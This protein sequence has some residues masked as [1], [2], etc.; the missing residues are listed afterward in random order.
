MHA[1]LTNEF[2]LGEQNA[3][4]Y[5]GDPAGTQWVV[6]KIRNTMYRPGPS[7]LD[8]NDDLGANSATFIWDMLGMYPENPGSG[9]LVFSSPGFPHEVI[10]L[11]SGKQITITSPGASPS[12]FYVK[13]LSINGAPDSK[14][15]VPFSRLAKG[16]M[17][18]WSLGTSPTRWGSAPRDAPPSYGGVLAH[19][20]A[21][22]APFQLTAARWEPEHALRRLNGGLRRGT[23]LP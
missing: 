17:L 18:N 2:D 6:N 4:D 19:T 23:R 8:N 20:P 15:Y 5:A 21:Q 1:E 10:T 12:K 14:L 9:N 16:A 13:S 3:L 11:P 22:L 7:G